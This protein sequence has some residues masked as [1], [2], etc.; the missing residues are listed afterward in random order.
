MLKHP[1]VS[2]VKQYLQGAE[3]LGTIV[4]VRNT[5]LIKMT[6]FLLLSSCVCVFMYHRDSSA[7]IVT[8]YGLWAQ[9]SVYA[10]APRT[11]DGGKRPASCPGHFIPCSHSIEDWGCPGPGFCRTSSSSLCRDSNN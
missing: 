9:F 6:C 3:A 4:S 1:I 5:Y 2:I 11:L 10:A 8:V 7:S